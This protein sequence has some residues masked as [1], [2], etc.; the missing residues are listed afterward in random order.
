MTRIGSWVVKHGIPAKNNS[1]NWENKFLITTI[2]GISS[3]RTATTHPIQK[4]TPN[5][6]GQKKKRQRNR[7]QL[8]RFIVEKR[9]NYIC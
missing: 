9:E 1:R 5:S 4:P 3:T 7:Y 6:K 8:E 2:L